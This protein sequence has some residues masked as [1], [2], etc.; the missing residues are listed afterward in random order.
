MAKILFDISVLQEPA[1]DKQG[2]L[3]M[4]IGQRSFAYAAVDARSNLLHLRVYEMDA[5]N[6]AEWCDEWRA[7]FKADDWLKYGPEK[8]TVVYNLP[9]S[10]LVPEQYYSPDTGNDM[11]ALFHGDLNNGITLSERIE[12]QPQYNVFRVPTAIHSLL[13]T[14]FAGSQFR[15]YYSI[16]LQHNDK[17]QLPQG[18]YITAVFYPNR[19]LAGVGKSN[20]LQLVQSFEYEAAEDVGYYL[21][22]IC[23]QLQLSP[24]ETPVLLSGMI[25]VS[26]VLYTEIFK[27]FA[28][29]ELEDFSVPATAA[30]V[31]Q[32]YPSHFFSPLL[33]LA[34]CVS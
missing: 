10:Q 27:Y 8:K 31:L 7:L 24:A 17:K 26:S 5:R 22:N 23:S 34:L 1:D 11:V 15:H 4:E 3:V 19:I 9:E 20:Q 18:D 2:H 21:L 29:V 30:P 14:S 33:K 28:L 25:D 6:S 13:Q 32:D 16:W 12:G